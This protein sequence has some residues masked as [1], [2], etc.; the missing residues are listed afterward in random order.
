M[1]QFFENADMQVKIIVIGAGAVVALF[2]G[3]VFLVLKFKPKP[4]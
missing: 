2:V 3:C 4:S 1:T